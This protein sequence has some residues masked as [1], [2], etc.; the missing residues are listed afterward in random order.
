MIDSISDASD[1]GKVSEYD[2]IRDVIRYL[3]NCFGK[4]KEAAVALRYA[5]FH[6]LG[7]T[8]SL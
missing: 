5:S 8:R 6:S 2:S 1:F 4:E 3:R 7:K